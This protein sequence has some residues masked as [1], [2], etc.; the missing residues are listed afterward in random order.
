M[1]GDENAML[2]VDMSEYMEKHTVSKLI[3]S[4]PGYV[5]YDEGGQLTEK[6]RRR[7]YSVLLFDEIEKAHED[8]FNIMLQIMEDGILTDAQGRR[9]DFK[10]TIIVMTSNVGA[11]NI[12]EK[13]KKLGF[14]MATGD[15]ETTKFETIKGAVMEEL[16]RTFKPEFLNR[17]DETIVFHQLSRESIREISGKMLDIVKARI[18]AMGISITADDK[19]LDLLSEKGFDPIYGARPLRRAIQSAVEDAAAEKI[20]D[21]TI[22]PGDRVT[23]TAVD[24]K[25]ELVKAAG[26]NA[27]QK[28]PAT[29]GV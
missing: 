19:A 10:N 29:A 25:I 17:I 23:I 21:G 4:P 6:V 26:T 28:L 9:V 13:Q 20:L 2:R 3:G 18:E 8:V 5:G 14:A 11:R 22:K 16:K 27:G 15:E 7:P 24:G 1:F 12:T